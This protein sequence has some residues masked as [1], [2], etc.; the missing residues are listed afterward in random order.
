MLPQN[1]LKLS[2]PKWLKWFFFFSFFLLWKMLQFFSVSAVNDLTARGE[3]KVTHS[4][5]EI[6]F[7]NAVLKWNFAL[8]V[9]ERRGWILRGKTTIWNQK[10]FGL[11]VSLCCGGWLYYSI[12][13]VKEYLMLYL[14]KL[15]DYSIESTGF[16]RCIYR[17]THHSLKTRWFL[18]YLIIHLSRCVTN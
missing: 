12:C 2:E 16:V 5:F 3:R 7:H 18:F 13:A 14:L 6:Q 11:S 1:K 8:G 15:S 9:N 17:K 10:R 4:G